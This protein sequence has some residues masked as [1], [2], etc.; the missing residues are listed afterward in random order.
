MYILVSEITKAFLKQFFDRKWKRRSSKENLVVLLVVKRRRVC[1]A[2]ICL[3]NAKPAKV[4]GFKK[5][6]PQHFNQAAFFTCYL[7]FVSFG[8]FL[9]VWVKM[10]RE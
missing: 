2:S 10:P 6:F 8:F 5:D 1:S 3:P 4:Q 7:A 9:G